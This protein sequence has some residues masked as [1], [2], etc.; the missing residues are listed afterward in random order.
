MSQLPIISTERVSIPYLLD[1]M[2]LSHQRPEV[3]GIVHPLEEQPQVV[4]A[5]SC[6]IAHAGNAEH[7][8]TLEGAEGTPAGPYHEPFEETHH[9]GGGNLLGKLRA[10]GELISLVDLSRNAFLVLLPRGV[11][12][13]PVV[14]SS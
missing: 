11:L 6:P 10:V 5:R 3:M 8:V 13:R 7:L 1:K 12:P 9:G 14:M 4:D 2:V